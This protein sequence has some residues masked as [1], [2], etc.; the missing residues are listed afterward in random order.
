MVKYKV[1]V[2][3]E[4]VDEKVAFNGRTERKGNCS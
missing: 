3:L 4:V 1:I 2:T